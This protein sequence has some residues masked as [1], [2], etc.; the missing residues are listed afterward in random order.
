MLRD[1]SDIS[2]G[3]HFSS[4]VFHFVNF[5]IMFNQYVIY[6]DHVIRNPVD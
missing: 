2:F 5:A 1:I 4:F 6:M 3:N